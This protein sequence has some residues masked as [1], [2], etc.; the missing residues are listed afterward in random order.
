VA[1]R[2]YGEKEREY[3]RAY[4]AK[5]RERIKARM[6][7]R[8]QEHGEEIR[9]YQRRWREQNGDRIHEAGKAYRARNPER[10]AAGKRAWARAN[11]EKA[12]ASAAR[13]RA[14]NPRA[15]KNAELRREH[16]ITLADYEAQLAEQGGVCAICGTGE[17]RAGKHFA[18]D[19]DHASGARRGLLCMF[20]N[21]RLG[22][23]EDLEWRAA[24]E[25]YLTTWATCEA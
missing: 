9:A 16:G 2:T 5:N 14:K 19:H 23:L 17:P 6:R 13:S 1:K 22:V 20:C 3:Q 4:Y 21:T 18:V 12:N 11:P 24:A 25:R 15:R 8:Q 7:Q 10:V